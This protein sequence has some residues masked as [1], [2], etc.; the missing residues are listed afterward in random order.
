MI[1]QALLIRTKKAAPSLA[2]NNNR[3]K[4]LL[5]WVFRTMALWGSG[6]RLPTA[7][8]YKTEINLS[9]QNLSVIADMRSKG[10]S[11][12]HVWDDWKKLYLA[13]AQ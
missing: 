2:K 1:S 7:P 4:G 8:P 11:P 10:Q 13:Y 6:V 5:I 9:D 3:I 12:T